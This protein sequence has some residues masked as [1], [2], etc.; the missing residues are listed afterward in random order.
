ME[1]LEKGEN[2]ENSKRDKMFLDGISGFLLALPKTEA[3]EVWKTI[4][5]PPT[6]EILML[7]DDIG[8]EM[9]RI[10]ECAGEIGENEDID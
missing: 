1:I 6:Y 9:D 3:A 8:K 10:V 7:R 5:S 2:P 4:C